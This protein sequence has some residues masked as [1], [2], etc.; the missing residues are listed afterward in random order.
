M[1]NEARARKGSGLIGQKFTRLTVI[2]RGEDR[3]GRPHWVCECICGNR[4]EPWEWNLRRGFTRSCGCLQRE[5]ALRNVRALTKHGGHGTPTY[6]SYL[7]AKSRCQNPNNI[8]YAD[9]G[10]RGIR[11]LYDSFEA[12]LEDMGPRPPGTT[13]ERCD[14]HGHY[15]PGNCRWASYTE[16]NNNRRSNRLITA[17]GRTR[18]IARWAR[19]V[20]I[21]RKALERRVRHG[22]APEDAL[23]RPIRKLSQQWRQR[24]R[25]AEVMP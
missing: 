25:N 7:S 17:F 2:A 16:Q 12:F 5:H 11:F 23:T 15:E 9:Y 24:T 1:S 14:N 22:W 20:G 3:K 21:D 4:I 18:T 8:A 19:E 10:G 6:R 13:L